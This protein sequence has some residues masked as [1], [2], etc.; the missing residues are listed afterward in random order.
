MNFLSSMNEIHPVTAMYSAMNFLIKIE[1][2]L[3]LVFFDKI[4]IFK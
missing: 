3:L 1:Y 4:Q 2:N